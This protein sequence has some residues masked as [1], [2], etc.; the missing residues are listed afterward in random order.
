MKSK[1]FAITRN[2]NFVREYLEKNP[3]VDCGNDNL[4]V[5]DFDHVRGEKVA[6]I[7]KMVSTGRSLSS[8]LREIEKCEV[9]CANCH[10]I[11]THQRRQQERTKEGIDYYEY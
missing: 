6:N 10:R 11:V 8:L 5:L 4:V 1:E 9:R 2:R 7:S 3:C